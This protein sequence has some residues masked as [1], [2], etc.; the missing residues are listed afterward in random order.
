MRQCVHHVKSSISRGALRRAR[1][2]RGRGRGRAVDDRV[3]AAVTV[4]LTG[5]A[6]LL[7]VG[8]L[9]ARGELAIPAD[10][11][12]TGQRSKPEEPYQTHCLTLPMLRR[13]AKPVP[14]SYE[15]VS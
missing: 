6:L 14:Q 4:R 7:D 1:D 9:A 5:A 3:I 2:R 13:K 10:H 15:H 12:A 11:T 8:Q